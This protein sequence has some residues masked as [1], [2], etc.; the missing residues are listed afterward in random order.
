MS[1][2]QRI[3]Y[4][5]VLHLIREAKKLGWMPIYVY[6]GGEQVRVHSEKQTLDTVFS[7]DES[8][9][10][11]RKGE[12][13]IGV[14]IVLGNEYDV[15]ADYNPNEEFDL[16]MRAVED[17]RERLEY[18]GNILNRNPSRSRRNPR[19]RVRAIEKS[20]AIEAATMRGPDRGYLISQVSLRVNRGDYT[21]A[22]SVA[23][24]AA[25]ALHPGASTSELDRAAE[26]IV[27]EIASQYTSVILKP[28]RRNPL[29]KKGR[30]IRRAMEREYGADAGRRVFYASERA[31]KIQGVKR[32]P[33]RSSRSLVAL[34]GQRS[35]QIHGFVPP[36]HIESASAHR[37]A[38]RAHAQKLANAHGEPIA[39][40]R[41]S[42]TT[43]SP[44][45]RE[46]PAPRSEALAKAA[47][48][49]VRFTGHKADR[50]EEMPFPDKPGAGLAVG[51]VLMIGYSATRDGER[52]NYLHKFAAHARP[53]LVAS[54]DGKQLFLLGGRYTFT[55]RGIVDERATRRT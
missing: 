9:I 2:R 18:T 46:N 41:V 7:V 14:L 39:F 49:F 55:D 22:L 8:T 12:A 33:I 20:H 45:M 11:F 38:I 25:K 6:D 5:I 15:I 36:E 24:Q 17:Y 27:H 16:I 44:R 52:A 42:V 50:I 31:G 3:E 4:N 28:T 13:R 1:G 53:M 35:G 21:G 10:T 23:Y 29:T 40:E 26:G 30:K 34:V 54:E 37:G 47:R 32:N 51:P 48:R 43:L 19:P